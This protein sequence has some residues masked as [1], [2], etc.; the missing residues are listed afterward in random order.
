MHTVVIP[1]PAGARMM[2]GEC[3]WLRARR[4]SRVMTRAYDEAL[5][6]LGIQI[7][8][9]GLLNV[10]ALCGE[11]GGG[12]KTIAEILVMDRTTLSRNLRPLERGGFVK[13]VPAPEDGRARRV[14]LT[15]AG[16]RV[17][18]EATPLWEQAHRATVAALGA[19]PAADLRER[20]DAAVVAAGGS[21]VPD[22]RRPHSRA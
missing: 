4:L 14:M 18:E 1:P 6:P 21:P 16:R 17:I 11:G 9:L 3:L 20:L 7:S 5:R 10:V 2:A 12:M 22:V 19:K 13:V 8:Q 15:P